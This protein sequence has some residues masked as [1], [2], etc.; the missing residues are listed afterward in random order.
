MGM[1]SLTLASLA[2]FPAIML[3]C[4]ASLLAGRVYDRHGARVLLPVGFLLIGVFAALVSVFISTGSVLVILL[5][6]PSP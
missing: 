5:L 1:D 4:V 3:S 6:Y 2:L